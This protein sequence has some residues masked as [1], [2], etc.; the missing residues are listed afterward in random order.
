MLSLLDFQSDILILFCLT[1]C[2]QT[3]DIFFNERNSCS[4]INGSSKDKL[5][6]L[7]Q[8][9]TI[10]S[11][12]LITNVESLRDEKISAKLN[13]LCKNNTIQLVAIDEIHKCEILFGKRENNII[14]VI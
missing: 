14:K 13:E 9:N 12:F 2:R 7:E 11:Y 10:S 6:D 4:F 5:H 3:S 8:L 1:S